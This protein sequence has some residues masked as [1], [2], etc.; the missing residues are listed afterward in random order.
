MIDAKT[1]RIQVEEETFLVH[2]FYFKKVKFKSDQHESFI[3]YSRECKERLDSTLIF[4]NLDKMVNEDLL[5]SGIFHSLKDRYKYNVKISKNFAIDVLAHVICTDQINFI[6]D[7]VIPRKLMQ[8]GVELENV[9]LIFI[10]N[11]NTKISLEKIKIDIDNLLAFEIIDQQ[12]YFKA[13]SGKILDFYINNVFKD[14]KNPGDDFS[15]LKRIQALLLS[16]MA[17]FSLQLQLKS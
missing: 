11:E 1:H 16:R 10:T 15:T 17:T 9:V 6:Q 7:H 13:N 14:V 3:S 8:S 12:E 5:I 4:M 2:I